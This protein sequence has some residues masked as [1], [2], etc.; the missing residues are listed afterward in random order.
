MSSS[1]VDTDRPGASGIRAETREAKSSDAAGIALLIS[2]LGYPCTTAQMQARLKG[3]DEDPAHMTFVATIDGKLSGMIGAFVGRIYEQ[4]ELIG[5]IIALS[6]S[7]EFQGQ[8]VGTLLV[9]T[10]EHWISSHGAST[11]LVN[12]GFHRKDAHKFYEG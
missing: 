11:I 1:S 6:V 3:M 5:R 10:A 9:Q 12:S 8:G 7:K 2:D 4:D